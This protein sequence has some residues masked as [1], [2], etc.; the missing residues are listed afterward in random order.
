MM[1]VKHVAEALNGSE[2]P[3]IGDRDLF[4]ECKAKGIVVVR[5][6]SD[7]V[8][9][10]D[11]AISDE[12]YDTVKLDSSGVL[13]NDCDEGENCPNYKEPKN[14]ATIK[15]IFDGSPDEPAWV[16]KTDIPHSTFNVMEDGEIF[17]RAI[18]FA[19]TDIAP[20]NSDESRN[21]EDA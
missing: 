4:A 6:H 15:P 7:D 18:V 10:F 11:G 1:D 8:M 20:R 13:N 12:F 5:G 21:G 19:L 16:F 9:V 2:Y 14:V 3:S 17:Q